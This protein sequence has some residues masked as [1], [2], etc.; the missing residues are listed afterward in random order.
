MDAASSPRERHVAILVTF[1]CP[2]DD[3][4]LVELHLLDP[5]AQAFVDPHAGSVQQPSDQ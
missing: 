5:H 4:V 1:A 3:P 2:N